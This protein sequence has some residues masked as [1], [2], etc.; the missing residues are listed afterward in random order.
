MENKFCLIEAI[1]VFARLIVVRLVILLQVQ[2]H[3][4]P[5]GDWL[6]HPQG[7]FRLRQLFLGPLV[8]AEV[9]VEPRPV[10]R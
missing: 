6:G 2:I 10:H 1:Q 8:L 9:I 3:N 5:V 7:F 4:R